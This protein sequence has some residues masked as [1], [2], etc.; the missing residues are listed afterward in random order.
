[1]LRLFAFHGFGGL[2]PVCDEQP[3]NGHKKTAWAAGKQRTTPL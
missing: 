3:G 1:M 2:M